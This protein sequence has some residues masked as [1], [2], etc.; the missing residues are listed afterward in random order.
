MHLHRTIVPTPIGPMLA[1]ASDDG[2]C[3]LEFDAPMRGG[4]SKPYSRHQ[5][6]EARLRHWFPPHEIDDRQ[7]PTLK[8]TREWLAAYFGGERA[9]AADVPLDLRGA[10]F[11]LRVWKE[12][13]GIPA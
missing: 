6:L 11:E 2:L 13:R 5:R 8:R 7:T 4:G 1:L 10:A 3:A 12:L 9:D